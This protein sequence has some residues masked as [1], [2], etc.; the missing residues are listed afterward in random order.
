[1]PKQIYDSVCGRNLKKNKIKSSLSFE[2]AKIMPSFLVLSPLSEINLRKY[3]RLSSY[4]QT[5]QTWN[6]VPV[7]VSC[8]RPKKYRDIGRK[9]S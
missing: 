6:C 1:M 8:G 5:E 3:F 4:V 2:L 7:F 9:A